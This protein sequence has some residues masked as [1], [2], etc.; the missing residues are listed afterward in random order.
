MAPYSDLIEAGLAAAKD[1]AGLAF[2]AY[3]RLYRFLLLYLAAMFAAIFVC[4][5]LNVAGL[6]ALIHAVILIA[7]PWSLALLLRPRIAIPVIL[8]DILLVRG[9]DD[10]RVLTMMTDLARRF[11]LVISSIT[12]AA[13]CPMLLLSYADLANPGG[14]LGGPALPDHDDHAGGH[15]RRV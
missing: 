12:Y 7:I 1:S 6:K 5:L 10:A 2:H 11:C 4:W 3:R 9:C 13:I 14:L 8:A 15:F